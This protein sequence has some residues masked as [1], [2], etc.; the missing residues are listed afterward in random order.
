M[1]NI[2]M[3]GSVISLYGETGMFILIGINKYLIRRSMSRFCNNQ[4]SVLLDLFVVYICEFCAYNTGLAQYFHIPAVKTNLAKTA[5]RYKGPLISNEIICKGVYPDTSEC[6]FV[7]FRKRF[8]ELLWTF[9]TW[10]YFF[11]DPISNLIFVS[12][13][14]NRSGAHVDNIFW[15]LPRGHAAFGR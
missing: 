12:D 3:L 10:Y 2:K 11:A 15:N 8:G 4:V 5:I 14:W 1:C 9:S 6:I 13:I 7:K